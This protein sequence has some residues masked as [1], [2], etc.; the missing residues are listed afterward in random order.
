MKKI[1]RMPTPVKITGRTSSITNAF[2]N[3]IIPVIEPTEEE[4]ESALETLG[5]DK[6]H[7]VC[8]YCGNP[9]TEW[10]H[11]HP[12]IKDKMPTGYISE[13]HNL[14]P[15]CGKCNQSKGNKYWKTWMLSDATLSPS[16]RHI[17][18][19]EQRIKHL[20]DYEQKYAP[21]KIDFEEI[22]G[23]DMWEQHWANCQALH[24][25]MQES[26]KHSDKLKAIIKNTLSQENTYE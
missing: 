8:A 7:I 18:D 24:D 11:F 4:I 20:E 25:L 13:I 9:Y 16:S 17:P 6:D 10:D 26:Q 15:A 21:I 2:V 1:F 23:K 14:V 12:L 22:I 5:M 19:I 3:G